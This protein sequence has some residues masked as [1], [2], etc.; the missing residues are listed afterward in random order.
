MPVKIARSTPRPFVRAA[1]AAGSQPYLPSGFQ[2]RYKIAT[3]HAGFGVIRGMSAQSID[4]YSLE[5]FAQ[6]LDRAEEECK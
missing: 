6:A 5:G 1:R 2:G 3:L 4:V